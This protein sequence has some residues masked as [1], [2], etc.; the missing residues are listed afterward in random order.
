MPHAKTDH[1][2]DRYDRKIFLLD[3]SQVLLNTLRAGIEP[4]GCRV[5][6]SID[7]ASALMRIIRWRPDLLVT[8]V[9]MGTIGGF[10][11]CLILKLM[12]DYAG[13]P[14]VVM[15]SDEGELAQREAA[16]AGADV[17]LHKDPDLVKNL[18][19]EMARLFA[20]SVAPAAP[21]E[22]A[23]RVLVVDDS[24]VMRRIIRN[25]LASLGI[26][27]VV[28]AENGKRA[29]EQMER[30]AFDLVMT[31]WN[32]PVMTG[33]EFVRAVRRESR[34]NL[35]PIIMVTSEGSF[36]AIAEAEAAGANGYV[37][38][39]FSKESLREMVAQFTS[40]AGEG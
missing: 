25:I 20:P 35:L 32:M 15:S 30:Q 33:L 26:A 5:E 2:L 18:R 9:E 23:R 7:P 37:S 40:D 31:D 17:Y 24:G 14:I 28:E 29:L 16:D 38:K 12:P 4:H 19:V 39:P 8:G 10:D 6:S 21:G 27:D 36:A 13:L 22:K 3:S 34:W 1:R 11:L